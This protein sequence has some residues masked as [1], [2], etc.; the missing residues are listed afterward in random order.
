M[1]TGENGPILSLVSNGMLKTS[2]E[3]VQSLLQRS[4]EMRW[5]VMWKKPQ[6][7][8]AFEREESVEGSRGW[9]IS[10][11]GSCREV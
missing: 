11:R 2:L 9:E 5:L 10:K 8:H 4:L 3:R 7:L 6:S 1:L